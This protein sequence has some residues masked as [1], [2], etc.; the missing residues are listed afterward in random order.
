MLANLDVFFGQ[1]YEPLG[2][3]R[4]DLA[5]VRKAATRVVVGVG[6]T[7]A[8]QVAHRAALA[9]ADAL[10]EPPV[11][12]PGDHAGFG[13]DPHGGAEVLLRLLSR[14]ED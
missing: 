8:G 6:T 12:F 3:H 4:P 13:T 11:P 10:G 9:V 7:S 5:A 14:H 2:A 1:M